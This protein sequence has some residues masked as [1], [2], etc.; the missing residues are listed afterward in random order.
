MLPSI[1]KYSY[2]PDELSLPLKYLLANKVNP[3]K[4]ILACPK[5]VPSSNGRFYN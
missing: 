1:P 4:L 5:M 3:S 2:N